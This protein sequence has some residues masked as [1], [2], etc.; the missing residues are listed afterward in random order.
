MRIFFTIALAIISI[1][2][3]VACGFYIYMTI[4][5]YEGSYYIKESIQTGILFL[6]FG[7]GA[8]YS[9]LDL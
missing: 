9:Q 4:I 6:M 5:Q 2:C 3:L 1:F 8:V 7:I